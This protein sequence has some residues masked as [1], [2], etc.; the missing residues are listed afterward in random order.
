MKKI[1]SLACVIA[2][3]ATL[4]GCARPMTICGVTYDSY[5]LI[6]QDSKKNPNVEYAP[7]WGNIFWGAFLVETVIAPIY[8][9]GFDL[10][11]PVGVKSE[12]KGQIGAPE[13][14]PAR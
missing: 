14:C 13:K 4:A 6:N 2:V 5:G 1:I 10:F 8:F 7:V 9:F 11:E 12:I 3:A